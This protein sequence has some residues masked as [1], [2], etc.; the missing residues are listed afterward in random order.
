MNSH[1]YE[2]KAEQYVINLNELPVRG[3]HPEVI[4][5]PGCKVKIDPK[6]VTNKNYKIAKI[7]EKD[8]NLGDMIL[9]C[10][11]CDSRIRITGFEYLEREGGK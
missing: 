3:R 7:E 2:P 11:G 10:N 9:E 8:G 4:R 1:P 6:D 5:C